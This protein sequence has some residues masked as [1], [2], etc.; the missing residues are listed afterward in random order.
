VFVNKKLEPDIPLLENVDQVSPSEEEYQKN[1]Q[2]NS[3][4]IV[5]SKNVKMKDFF[6]PD[7]LR[8]LE[9]KNDVCARTVGVNYWT[10]N[11]NIDRLVSSSTSDND[12]KVV[13]NL[14]LY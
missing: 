12:Q 11:N 2:N 6:A 9:S 14:N 10:E 1:D 13:S 4:W 7:Q 8:P 3:K 5:I